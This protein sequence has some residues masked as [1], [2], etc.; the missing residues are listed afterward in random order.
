MIRSI[1]LLLSAILLTAIA[2][3]SAMAQDKI[4]FS[5]TVFSDYS[6]QV[7]SPD[8]GAKGENGFGFRRVYLTADY[9]MSDKFS[10]RFRLEGADDATNAQGKPAPF[11]KDLYLR[12]NDAFGDSHR[13]T[14]GLTSPPMWTA[15]ESQ[16]GYRSL[17]KTIQDRI[18]IASSRDIGIVVDGPVSDKVRYAIMVA[19][20]SGG[21]AE[22]DKYKRVYGQ[23][24]FRPADNI[25]ATLGADYYQLEG[26]SSTS[27]NAF[28]GYTLE[29]ARLG[30]EGVYNPKSFDATEDTDNQ[31][32]LSLFANAD[33]TDKQRIVARYDLQDRD[34][35]GTQTSSNWAL[36]GVAFLVD[37]NVQI[38]PNVIYEKKDVDNDA[39]VLARLTV[40]ANF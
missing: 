9:K 24:D 26:G 36:L 4:S 23:L 37:K 10:G 20:N 27:M 29:K 16:W 7:S 32:G 1:R 18:K 8:D 33:L 35:L 28:I 19:N 17:E 31:F 5:G 6:Y 11:V 22:T 30:I 38:I 15:A 2:S 12:W 13:V 34:N 40:W 21:K 14:F 39:S 25:R 3:G